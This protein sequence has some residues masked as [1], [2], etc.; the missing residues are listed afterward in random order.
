VFLQDSGP[1]LLP[2]GRGLRT[3]VGKMSQLTFL[4]RCLG[5][6]P[7]PCLM[8]I[9]KD[10]RTVS[11][12][13]GVNLPRFLLP[14]WW[15]TRG[16]TVQRRDSRKGGAG[17]SGLPDR[18]HLDASRTG[19]SP[20]NELPGKTSSKGK[21]PKEPNGPVG[22]IRP[23]TNGCHGAWPQLQLRVAIFWMI[24][25]VAYCVAIGSYNVL[26]SFRIRAFECCWA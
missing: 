19:N 20:T 6:G 3:E 23:E 9:R 22:S 10:G 16:S 11:R 8:M 26:G 13:S 15:R 14:M 7:G 5:F 18:D 2:L 4:L 21:S 25:M 24:C 12:Q 1:S 17:Y